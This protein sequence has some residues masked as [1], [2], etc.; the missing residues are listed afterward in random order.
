MSKVAECSKF[1]TG[2]EVSLS[3]A[4][5][6]WIMVMISCCYYVSRA[7]FKTKEGEMLYL[8]GPRP[9]Q[10]TGFV[11][12]VKDAGAANIIA[13]WWAPLLMMLSFFLG[14][15][16]TGC[17]PSGVRK[18]DQQSASSFQKGFICI[19]TGISLIDM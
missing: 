15:Y 2:L 12:E 4:Q 1:Q 14:V 18:H 6:S 13:V 11:I 17:L 10:T 8:P 9:L 5:F 16:T 3:P 19:Q 7:C